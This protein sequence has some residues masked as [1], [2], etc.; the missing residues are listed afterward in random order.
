M[1]RNSKI[2]DIDDTPVTNEQALEMAR[3][4]VEKADERRRLSCI[5]DRPITYEE[6]RVLAAKL[7]AEVRAREAIDPLRDR[8]ARQR[9]NESGV[10]QR[11]VE[12]APRVV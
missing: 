7:V 10:T 8:L 4:M 9:A 3:R 6:A 2:S 1:E 11:Q 12:S 5:D